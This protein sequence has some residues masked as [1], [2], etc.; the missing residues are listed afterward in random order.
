MRRAGLSALLIVCLVTFLCPEG[1]QTERGHDTE[2]ARLLLQNAGVQN[3]ARADI[4]WSAMPTRIAAQE[5]LYAFVLDAD[6]FLPD[7]RRVLFSAF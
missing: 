3:D 2:S 5:L 6:S 7:L 4:A 1:G